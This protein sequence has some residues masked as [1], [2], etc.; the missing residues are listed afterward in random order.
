MISILISRV[1][2]FQLL[3]RAMNGFVRRVV[4]ENCKWKGSSG[5]EPHTGQKCATQCGQ[6]Q[7]DISS[8]VPMLVEQYFPHETVVIG[9]PQAPIDFAAIA[10]IDEIS[11]DNRGGNEQNSE[12]Q[13]DL[14]VHERVPSDF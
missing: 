1:A 2:V 11:T 12:A 9:A 13:S 4:L 8:A 7:A 5:T 10:Q 3:N 6:Q 14:N